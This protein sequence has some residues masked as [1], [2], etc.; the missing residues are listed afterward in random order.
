MLCENIFVF[1]LGWILIVESG[2]GFGKSQ[3]RSGG[4]EDDV[5]N[6][7]SGIEFVISWFVCG[8]LQGCMGDLLL[9]NDYMF[10]DME[11]NEDNFVWLEK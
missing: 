1:Q 4:L 6:D 7:D 9:R 3:D 11:I 8:S 10:I 5:F 2:F